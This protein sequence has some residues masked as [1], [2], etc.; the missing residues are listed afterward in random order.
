MYGNYANW[1]NTIIEFKSESCFFIG[2]ESVKFKQRFSLVKW[3]NF[4]LSVFVFLVSFFFLRK[5]LFGLKIDLEDQ[6]IG[7]NSKNEQTRIRCDQG[8]EKVGKQ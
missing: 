7:D 1:V 5:L 8:G 3:T 2:C 4:F 6:E